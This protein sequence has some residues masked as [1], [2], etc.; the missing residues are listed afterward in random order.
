MTQTNCITQHRKNKQLTLYR[1]STNWVVGESKELKQSEIAWIISIY[2]SILYKEYFAE[3]G[4]TVYE[5]NRK[6]SPNPYK[7]AKAFGFIEY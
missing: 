5:Q 3:T 6:S 7:F 2:R 1:K 4:Q